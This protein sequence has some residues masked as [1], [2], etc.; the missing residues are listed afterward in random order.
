MKTHHTKEAIKQRG[1]VFTPNSLVNEMLDRLPKEVFTNKDKTF[2]DNSCGNGA[3]LFEVMNR[4]M[5]SGASHSQALLNI[6]GVELDE[7][8]AEECRKRLL[9]NSESIE[10][11]ELVRLHIICADALDS[12]HPG[13]EEVGFY[14]SK[15]Y[16]D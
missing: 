11:K 8:N 6:F 1:E 14:W 9:G 13:W 3:F 2:L 16:P 10:L 7:K 5:K 12:K 4:K 15:L